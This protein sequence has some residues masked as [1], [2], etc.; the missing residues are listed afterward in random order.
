MQHA[1]LCA[2][3]HFLD[4]QRQLKINFCE[5][6]KNGRKIQSVVCIMRR[7]NINSIRHARI[8]DDAKTAAAKSK[9]MEWFFKYHKTVCMER[10]L[11]HSMQP[12]SGLVATDGKESI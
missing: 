2:E 4:S 5:N 11:S 9:L 1:L 10:N 8:T 7:T 12:Q 3:A 6:G